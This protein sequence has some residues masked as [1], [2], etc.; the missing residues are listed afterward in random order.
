MDPP[1][2][3]PWRWPLT[4][5]VL[6]LAALALAGYVVHRAQSL[7]GEILEGGR[8]V[9][10]ELRSVAAAF[11]TGTITTTF[12]SYATEVS[13]SHRLQ[14]ATLQEREVFERTDRAQI[15]WG[16]LELPE[17]VVKAEAPVEYTYY[18]DLDERWDFRIE[19]RTVRVEAPAIRFNTP[20]IDVS[21]LEYEV[22][23]ASVFRD[24]ELAI[25]NLKR[26][27]S[28]LARER[29]SAN[30]ELVRE[31]GRKKTAEFTRTWLLSSYDDASDY[32]VEV[33]FADEALSPSSQGAGDARTLR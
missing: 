29:A 27:L 33:T 15:L 32:G 31:L 25:E 30:L 2:S 8:S 19:G 11:K 28:Q 22:E 13:G 1:A 26:G 14:F 10:K 20:A 17:V 9:A 3:S 21:R 24:E 5:L 4:F 16:Q 6:G 18:L 7:P 12:L 23:A